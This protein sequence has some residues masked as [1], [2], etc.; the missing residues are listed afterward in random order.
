MGR[1]SQEK[2]TGR[3]YQQRKTFP[4]GVRH[5]KWSGNKRPNPV[6]QQITYMQT[7][8]IQMFREALMN[9]RIRR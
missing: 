1:I 4:R 6:I 8:A 2:M 3:T 9:S 5:T 7:M